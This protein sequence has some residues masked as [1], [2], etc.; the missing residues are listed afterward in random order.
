MYAELGLRI[1]CPYLFCAWMRKSSRL[2][3]LL[4]SA[5]SKPFGTGSPDAGKGG[6]RRYPCSWSSSLSRRSMQ[7][8][9]QLRASN[10]WF[11]I[12]G[13]SSQ[14]SP[15]L[16][17]ANLKRVLHHF[18]PDTCF[19]A[20]YHRSNAATPYQCV[21]TVCRPAL[22]REGCPDRGTREFSPAHQSAWTTK[23]SNHHKSNRPPN[24]ITR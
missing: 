3:I 22:Q 14:T 7:R 4:G 20:G 15:S 17:A 23:S 6:G 1:D 2:R 16:T 10:G 5:F 21:S 11:W 12:L 24:K 9:P 18:H 19:P 13:C 8:L